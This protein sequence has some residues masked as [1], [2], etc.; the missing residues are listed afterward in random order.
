MKRSF[1]RVNDRVSVHGFGP[2]KTLCLPN[3]GENVVLRGRVICA[4]RRSRYGLSVVVLVDL[5]HGEQI[6]TFT[7]TGGRA[8]ERDKTCITL[9]WPNVTPTPKKAQA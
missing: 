3:D 6:E 7:E 9:G 1:F 5:P 8:L 4:N 2:A